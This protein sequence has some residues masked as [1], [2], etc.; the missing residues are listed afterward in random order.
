MMKHEVEALKEE[1][2]GTKSSTS[3]TTS[4]LQADYKKLF[5]PNFGL[6]LYK[7]DRNEAKYL[8]FTSMMPL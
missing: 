6:N 5:S 3:L 4:L 8:S 2:I 1:E 7:D